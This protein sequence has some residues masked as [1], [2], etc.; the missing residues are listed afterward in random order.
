M[1]KLM[2]G[3]MTDYDLII[4]SW[5]RSFYATM[6]P[7]PEV[8]DRSGDEPDGVKIVF[9]GYGYNEET[10][11]H[12]DERTLYFAVF[13]HK[14]SLTSKTF[15]EHDYVFGAIVH[16]PKEEACIH[17]YLDV[18]N[19]IFDLN[20]TEDIELDHELVGSIIQHIKE[21]DND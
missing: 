1:G 17:C 15:P 11:E 13:I 18:E 19:D 16:R 2:P 8:G 6:Q 9:E 14:E 3:E 5:A 4:E 20:P 10:D 21:R 12:D 7:D